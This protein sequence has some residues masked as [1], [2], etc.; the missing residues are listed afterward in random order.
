MI[1]AGD[2]SSVVNAIQSANRNK[3]PR[4]EL[5]H[6]SNIANRVDQWRTAHR[7]LQ[8]LVRATDA[9]V[10][11]TAEEKLEYAEALRGMGLVQEAITLLLEI[12]V[13]T[14]PLA[15]IRISFCLMSQWRYPEAANYLRRYIAN[16]E[17]LSESKRYTLTTA[18]VNLA[19]TLVV[20]GDDDEAL[21]LLNSLMAETKQAG[22]HLLFGNC[23]ELMAQLFVRQGKCDLADR[24]LDEAAASFSEARTR[25]AL[26]W[27]KWKAISKSIRSQAVHPELLQCRDEALQEREWE[28]LRECDLYIGFLTKDQDLLTH[29]YFGTPFGFYRKRILAL[30]GQE[31]TLPDTYV[32]NQSH[33]VAVDETF[34][35]LQGRFDLGGA[36]IET[37]HLMHRMLILLISDF[38]RPLTTGTAFS[39][40][41]PGENYSQIGSSNR[42][43][44]VINRLR[45]W[46]EKNGDL[47]SIEEKDGAYRLRAK[48][49]VGI[50]IPLERP[51]LSSEAISWFQLKRH[52]QN[53]TFTRNDIM[54]FLNC[55]PASANRL[56]RWAVQRGQCETISA[57]VRRKYRIL[58]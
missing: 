54:K 2:I 9:A 32:W 28:T 3:I 51:P 58:S 7:F 15:D 25:F 4:S 44:Q 14:H 5:V 31:F 37:G 18:K 33:G 20:T 57:G 49:G 38:Y 35:L 6:Y 47:I 42:V 43:Y 26:Y 10:P 40:L 12:D 34:D 30:A 24:Y 19:A 13:K 56:L 55:S 27:R 50:R 52:I 16:E 36:V 48:P 8:P 46:F 53:E 41:F 17:S 21:K 39:E 29:V 1:Q 11:A 22:N 45:D 23:L